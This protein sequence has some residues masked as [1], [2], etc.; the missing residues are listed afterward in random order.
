M[1]C[2]LLFV[3]PLF[4]VPKQLLWIA[5]LVVWWRA[6]G[7]RGW[8]PAAWTAQDTVFAGVV[9][10]SLL[11]GAGAAAWPGALR[12]AGDPIRMF[13][14]AW[15]IARSPYSMREAGMALAAAVAGAV[16]A[17]CWGLFELLRAPPP[18]MFELHSV[19]HVNHS[20]IYLAIAC[21]AAVGLALRARG[22]RPVGRWAVHASVLILLVCLLISASRAA[23]GAAVLHLAVTAWLAPGTRDPQGGGEAV[24]RGWLTR[25]RLRIVLLTT[26]F[27]AAI[28]YAVVGRVSPGPLQPSGESFVEKFVSRPS[29]AGLLAFRDQLWRVAGLAF[30]DHPLFGIGNDRFRTLTRETLCAPPRDCGTQPLY[31]AAHAHSLYANTLAERG[32]FGIAWLVALLGSWAVVLWRMRDDARGDP[33]AAMIWTASLGALLVSAAA[34]LLN[35][36]LHHEHGMLAMAMLGLLLAARRAPGGVRQS[37]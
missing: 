13:A 22:T 10:A 18:A 3:L 1:L 16:V 6:R 11:A 25:S 23:I 34:G 31:F 19:G 8:N 24:A 35:T 20:A 4:E 5:F 32:I 14:T 2:A 30:Q 37:P 26:V 12:E 7:P 9:A 28:A 27:A 17:S 29:Q 15:M 21:A 33:G 36:T